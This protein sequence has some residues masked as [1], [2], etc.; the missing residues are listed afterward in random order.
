MRIRRETTKSDAGAR[1]VVL[2]EIAVWA[3]SEL[4]AR[5]RL[6]GASRPTD[7][8]LPANCSK[9]TKAGDPLHAR[10]GYD[11]TRPQGSWRSA[12]QKL[13]AAAGLPNLRFH[14]LRHSFITQAVEEGVPIEVVMAQ[15]G[16]ISAEMTRYYTHLGTDARERAATACRAAERISAVSFDISRRRRR[17]TWGS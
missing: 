10:R 11:V 4:L 13:R 3:A 1:E 8:L 2:N 17:T 5:A 15:V 6:L 16:H 12:W 7:Y 9:H 14:D